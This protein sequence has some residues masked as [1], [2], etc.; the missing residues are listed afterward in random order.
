MYRFCRDRNKRFLFRGWNRL[1][2]NSA[3]AARPVAAIKGGRVAADNDDKVPTNI[4]GGVGDD[5]RR[6]VE[7]S[8]LERRGKIVKQL[9]RKHAWRFCETGRFSSS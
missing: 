4:L 5:P 1:C 8:S 6:R 7:S 9:V 2:Q 3:S